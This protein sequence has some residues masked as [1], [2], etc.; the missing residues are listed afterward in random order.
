[1]F[2][3]IESITEQATTV[4]NLFIFCIENVLRMLFSVFVVNLEKN[5]TEAIKLQRSKIALLQFL[6][7][8]M[9]TSINTYI[10]FISYPKFDFEKCIQHF[11][12]EMFAE[13]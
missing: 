13:N 3:E 6:Q 10:S 1:M 11:G 2:S 7:S 12:S 9:V 4:I 5:D 8:K